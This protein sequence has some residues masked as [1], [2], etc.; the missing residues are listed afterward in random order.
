M[1]PS[2]PLSG[3]IGLVTGGGTGL[4]LA[5]A[6]SLAGAGM[7]VALL[8]RRAGVLAEA[9]TQLGPLALAVPCDVTSE[10]ETA[11]AVAFVRS[12]YGPVD[13]V[14]HAA[15]AI[16]PEARPLWEVDP[17]VTWS[18]VEACLRGPLL[19]DAHVLADMVARGRGRVVTVASEARAATI[20]GTYTGYAVGKR[21]A[22]LLTR[23]LAGSLAGTGVV[24]LDVLPGVV[25]TDLTDSMSVW[26]AHPPER[27]DDPQWTAATVLDVALGRHD[28]AAGATL[29]AVA[30]HGA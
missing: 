1:D 26:Q 23:A 5:V 9:A 15:A 4:G 14:V 13:L 7:R 6:R 30:L 17:A 27:W 28:D 10:E 29:D 8:G 21:A 24:A 19:L 20:S 22:S 12:Q 2:A 25:R 16:E 18:V 11:A 3:Q